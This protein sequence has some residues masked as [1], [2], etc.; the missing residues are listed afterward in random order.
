MSRS[1]NSPTSLSTREHRDYD[2]FQHIECTE[3]HQDSMMPTVDLCKADQPPMPV[4]T[5]KYLMSTTTA[6]GTLTST[7]TSTQRW[8]QDSEC[9]TKTRTIA[10]KTENTIKTTDLKSK[11]KAKT[12]KILSQDVSRP[13]H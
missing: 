5:S 11:T 6:T 12:M 1:L 10:F 2:E 13:R 8:D 7:T 9:K 3:T 4:P